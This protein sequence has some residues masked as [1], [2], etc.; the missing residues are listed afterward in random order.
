MIS[1]PS[2]IDVSGFSG[3]VPFADLPGFPVG[4]VAGHAGRLVLGT[5]EGTPVVVLQGRALL[6][7]LT[8]L[9]LVDDAA[10]VEGGHA[11]L[12]LL[13]RQLARGRG[14][15]VQRPAAGAGA[16]SPPAGAA[17]GRRPAR[18]ARRIPADRPAR[19]GMVAPCPCGWLKGCGATRTVAR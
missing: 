7:N 4:S 8:N 9:G 12:H 5:L 10:R 14:G 11:A 2:P 1:T 16:G 19:A 17:R 18:L 13:D 15:R 3:W 6:N